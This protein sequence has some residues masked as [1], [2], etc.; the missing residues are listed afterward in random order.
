MIKA[1]I[2]DM[3]GVII[4]TEPIYSSWIKTFLEAN[5]IHVTE[6]ERKSVTGLS[7]KE[8]EEVFV[9]WWRRDGY[10]NIS[11]EEI[12]RKFEAVIRVLEKCRPIPYAKVQDP[13]IKK[14]MKQMKALGYRIA[15]ASTSPSGHIERAIEEIGLNEYVDLY[16][17]GDMFRRS[18]PNPEIYLH[19]MEQL[20][21]SAKECIAVEDSA[22]GI[23]SAIRAGLTVIAKEDQ[24][25]DFDQSKADMKVKSLAEIPK[26]IKLLDAKCKCK[27]IN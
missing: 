4:D 21:V 17:S 5:Q 19:T 1:I 23:A 3:D 6:E 10:T 7:F 12:S 9:K 22:Y 14:V 8:L 18:K 15:I 2:F 27:K 25:F 20:G 26:I 11:G 24:Y 13:D 16:V